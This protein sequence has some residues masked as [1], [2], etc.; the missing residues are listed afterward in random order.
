VQVDASD[1]G[2]GD[3]LA[4]G[5][6]EAE[7]PILFISRKLSDR[8]QRYA[9]T[10]KEALAIKWALDYLRYYLPD[11][12][13]TGTTSLLTMLPTCGWPVRETITTE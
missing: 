6:G 13:S 2:L 4:Q 7:R 1:T 5:E 3:V 10:E 11:I 12:G 9:T 8:E